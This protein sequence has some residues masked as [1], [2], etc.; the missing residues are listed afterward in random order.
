MNAID[1]LI[2]FRNETE[3]EET[4]GDMCDRGHLVAGHVPTLHKQ[5]LQNRV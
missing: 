5:Y 1:W 4:I 3:D 2:D